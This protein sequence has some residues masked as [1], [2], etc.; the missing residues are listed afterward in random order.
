MNKQQFNLHVKNVLKNSKHHAPKVQD[1]IIPLAYSVSM[2]SDSIVSARKSKF[3]NG[4]TNPIKFRLPNGVPYY[5]TYNHDIQKI[6]L[7]KKN[8]RGETIKEF[9]NTNV[10][11]V[12]E[13]FES[14]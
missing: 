4:F 5:L 9:D 8:S 12:L 14:L 6:L 3:E 7:K 11:S 10:D 1:V 2:I 13:T